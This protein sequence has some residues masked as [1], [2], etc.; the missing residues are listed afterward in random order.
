MNY[1]DC[2]KS[3]KEEKPRDRDQ[4][5]LP[6][7]AGFTR[8]PVEPFQPSL[9]HP[10]WCLLQSTCMQWKSRTDRHHHN[11]QAILMGSDP[12]LLFRAAQRYKKD[13][14][15]GRHDIF[16]SIPHHFDP[17]APRNG[18]LFGKSDLQSGIFLR[19]SYF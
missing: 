13:P 12:F 18:G 19:Q 7:S 3:Y 11:R 16:R 1:A 2:F 15:L 9:L 4:V 5:T 6:Q 17:E 8:Q 14:D 10:A